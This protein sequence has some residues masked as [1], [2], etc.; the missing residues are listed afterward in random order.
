MRKEASLLQAFL[1][2]FVATKVTGPAR[3][4]ARRCK[5]NT[6][7]ARYQPVG[8]CFI[9]YSNHV[10]GS[11]KNAGCQKITDHSKYLIMKQQFKKLGLALAAAGLVCVQ[12]SGIPVHNAKRPKQATPAKGTWINLFDG[13]T[14][15]GWHACLPAPA[16]K[17]KRPEPR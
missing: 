6:N 2:T 17:T 3:S 14:L 16:C 1:V 8:D 10:L 11:G 4:G 7:E 9:P 5:S 15:K 12:T 13:K